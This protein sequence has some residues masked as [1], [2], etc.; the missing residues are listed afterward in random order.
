MKAVP[1]TA[2]SSAAS[3]HPAL[4]AWEKFWFDPADPTVLGLMRILVG[5][6]ALYTVLTWGIGL[7]RFVGPHAWMDAQ[8][9]EYLTQVMPFI[10]APTDW[11]NPTA[12]ERGQY[13]FSPFFHVT[14]PAWLYTIH[15]AILV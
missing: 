7:E 2:A 1:V 5:C 14:D 12:V 10:S 11:T 3:P 9:S 4:A 6:V 8:V 13:Y 15:C